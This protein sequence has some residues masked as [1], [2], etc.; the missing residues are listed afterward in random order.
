MKK[1]C[2]T[3]LSGNEMS[4]YHT[5]PLIFFRRRL[6]LH[7]LQFLQ[8]FHAFWMIFL[9]LKKRW[10]RAAQAAQAAPSFADW[11]QLFQSDLVI[12][13]HSPAAW[14]PADEEL[15]SPFKSKQQPFSLMSAS[16]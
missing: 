3:E 16:W 4:I 15:R 8:F 13:T 6:K 10:W 7:V 12:P 9:I 5:S 14:L 1:I 11:H 2:S